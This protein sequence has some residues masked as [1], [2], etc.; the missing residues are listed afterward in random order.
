MIGKVWF[1]SDTHFGA[2]RTL[3]LSR[4]PFKNVEEMDDIII[5]NWNEVVGENDYVIHLGD[6]GDYENVKKLNGKVILV[7]G[8]YE[9]KD[10]I[11]ADYLLDIG[12][13]KVF[14]TQ[15]TCVIN[16]FKYHLQH[17][18]SKCKTDLDE[19]EFNLFGHV[20][21]LQLVKRFGLNVGTDCHN[22]YPISMETVLFYKNG[23]N[24]YDEEVFM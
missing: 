17:E 15:T 14:T 19:N 10:N 23:F 21:K 12:F 22:F 8:N 24:F 3:E 16:G 2:E 9:V 11:T 5:R 13:Y 20:H 6:F 4:R 1:T 7:Y 18:P